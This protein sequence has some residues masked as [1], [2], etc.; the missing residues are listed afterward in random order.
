MRDLDRRTF[1]GLGVS[2]LG[3]LG[4]VGLGRIFGGRALA[5]DG[6]A[7]TKPPHPTKTTPTPTPTTTAPPPTTTTPPP[8][9]TTT[10]PPPTTTTTTPPPLPGFPTR[11][12]ALARPSLIVKTGTQST[13]YRVDFPPPETTFDLRTFTST[14]YGAATG[15][16]VLLGHSSSGVASK[17]VTVGGKVYGQQSRSLTWEQLQA[18]ST[19]NGTALEVD[20]GDWMVVYDLRCDNT[21]DGFRPRLFNH[22]AQDNTVQFLVEGA[23]MTYV[24]DDAIED[25]DLMTCWIRD[26]LFDGVFSG[27]SAKPGS[28]YTY[29]NT[30]MVMHVEDVVLRMQAMPRGS[31][32]DG[33][34]HSKIWKWDYVKAGTVDAKR[35]TFMLDENPE[36]STGTMV[37]P[38]GVYENITLILGPGFVG[39]YPVPLPAGVTVTRDTS[40][41][42][43]ARASWLVA[44]PGMV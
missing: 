29:T 18:N 17:P 25:D 34:A 27:F 8:T 33:F 2:A 11:D 20:A 30:S 15:Y 37:W 40:I 39:D 12:E 4:F 14:A 31:A 35:C 28:S 38:N 19:Y 41:Y 7:A 10:T 36:G 3:A 42:D 13:Q 26:C 32:A 1:L 6:A 5:V 23:Y 9:T 21:F 22:Q 43:A 44:H 16:P 24:R